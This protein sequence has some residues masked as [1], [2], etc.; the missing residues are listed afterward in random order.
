[1]PHPSFLSLTGRPLR[2]VARRLCRPIFKQHKLVSADIFLS[3]GEIVGSV[4]AQATVPVKLYKTAAG[5]ATLRVHV[6]RG[7]GLEIRY[8]TPKLIARL[9][10]YFG[11][12]C[13]QKLILQMVDTLPTMTPKDP[14]YEPSEE[15]VR[16]AACTLEEALQRL[17]NSL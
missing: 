8:H 3:W 17:Q 4:Y 16:E 5:E 6:L 12:P 11:F 7:Q 14:L 13:V 1:M 15:S 10:Q 9:H 2:D